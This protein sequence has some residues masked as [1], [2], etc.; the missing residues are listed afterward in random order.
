MEEKRKIRYTVCF[1]ALAAALIVL[2]VGNAM[3]GSAHLGLGETL[4]ILLYR[5]G[6]NAAIIWGIRLPRLLAAA[7][8]GGA[9]AVSGFLL[10]T[11]FGNPIA[12]PFVLGRA[13]N[14]SSRW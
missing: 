12:G 6:D 9:L 7:I 10:Q 2:L 8:L 4:R 11:F 13:R 5:E 1:L 3:T 14:S